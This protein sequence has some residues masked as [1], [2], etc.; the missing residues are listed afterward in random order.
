LDADYGSACRRPRRAKHR[1]E[2]HRDF[3]RQRPD[4]LRPRHADAEGRPRHAGRRGRRRQH[5]GR[6]PQRH[7]GRLRRLA[8]RGGGRRTGCQRHAR[9]HAPRRFSGLDSEH[10]DALQSC[11]AGDGTDRSHHAG[12]RGRAAIRPGP[13]LQG[14]G[15]ADRKVAHGWY[16]NG[17]CAM[18][19]ATT[20]GPTGWMRRSPRNPPACAACSPTPATRHW[21][22][23]GRWPRTRPPAPSTV[24]R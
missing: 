24:W 15:P 5:G 1:S 13:R 12:G 17:R 2:E 19:R 20:T 11:Q 21:H 18:P 23:P 22:G 9:T 8:E 14:G 7:L 10:Q 6:R 16:G 4:C 3:E